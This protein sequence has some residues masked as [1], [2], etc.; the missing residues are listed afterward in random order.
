MPEAS[1]ETPTRRV[2]GSIAFFLTL[3]LGWGVGHYYVGRTRTAIV[4]ASLQLIAIAVIATSLVQAALG[5]NP[6]Y[7]A[8][9]WWYELTTAVGQYIRTL[10]SAPIAIW[11]AIDAWSKRETP[12]AGPVRLPGYFAIWLIPLA[13]AF[14]GALYVRE[15]VAQPFR[16]PSG[17]MQPTLEIGEYFIATPLTGN[18]VRAGDVVVYDAAEEGRMRQFVKRVIALPGQ[19]F[20]VVGGRLII[21]GHP[22]PRALVG[23]FVRDGRRMARY[24]ETLGSHSYL[25]EYFADANEALP[26]LRDM[27]E[28]MVPPGQMVV[29]GDARDNSR[30]SRVTGPESLGAVRRR[31][32]RII[33]SSERE[34]IGQPL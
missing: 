11:A 24:R 31:A 9:Q 17:A 18:A 1:A 15:Y 22:I 13:I 23:E 6:W 12:Q 14:G 29:V 32:L 27:P 30:D 10:V 28:L 20:A 34:R 26:D 3:L 2:R 21:D 19:R 16:S 8:S 25:T 4:L 5:P 33:W 7:A